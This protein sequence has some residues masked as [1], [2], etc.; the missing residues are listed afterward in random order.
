VLGF[1]GWLD[2]GWGWG[3]GGREKG[4]KWEGVGR[5]IWLDMG[6]S[7]IIW[8]DGGFDR[9]GLG[10]YLTLCLHAYLIRIRA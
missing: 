8:L 2:G 10:G 1:L 5:W 6:L 3:W 9:I 7:C 4:V